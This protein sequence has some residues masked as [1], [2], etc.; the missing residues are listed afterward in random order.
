MRE[1]RTDVILK[2]RG[3]LDLCGVIWEWRIIFVVLLDSKGDSECRKHLI[4]F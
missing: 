4:N 3:H 2:V 1:K